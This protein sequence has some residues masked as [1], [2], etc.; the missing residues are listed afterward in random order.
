MDQRSSTSPFIAAEV[1]KPWLGWK[2][3][4]WEVAERS[5]LEVP[6]F[7]ALLQERGLS[8]ETPFLDLPI[9]DKQN[10]LIPSRQQDLQ[11]EG[12]QDIFT[13]FRSAGSTGS[14]LYWPQL[15]DDYRWATRQMRTFLERSFAIHNRKTLAIMA[16]ALG[17]W[18]GGDY[19]S[20]TLKNVAMD[21]PYLFTVMSPGDRH[22]EVI[23]CLNRHTDQ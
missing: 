8:S 4:A 3:T 2:E 5:K 21:A 15:K 6:A 7:R 22:E 18:V 12:S 14:P 20:W 1:T 11:S 10:Y 16:M 17:S 19:Y 9:T 23:E 13:Y